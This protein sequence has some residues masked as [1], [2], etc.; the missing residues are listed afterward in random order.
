MSL[1]IKKNTTFKIPRT[2]SGAPS[3]ISLTA[4]VIYASGLSLSNEPP[5]YSGAINNPYYLISS[6]Y[7]LSGDGYGK[8]LYVIGTGWLFYAYALYDALDQTPTEALVA[9]NT[10]P[11]TSLPTTGWTNLSSDL[12]V[13][14]TLVI[15]TTP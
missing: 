5:F 2:G 6:G 7:W 9:I 1:I 10:A 12:Y 11:A 3:G 14:G 15:S 8:V 4:P 13:E